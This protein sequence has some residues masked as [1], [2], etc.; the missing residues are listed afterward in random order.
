MADPAPR[1]AINSGYL[2]VAVQTLGNSL[3]R[4]RCKH[5][6]SAKAQ[7]DAWWASQS[8]R[9]QSLSS[10]NHTVSSDRYDAAVRVQDEYREAIRQKQLAA[11]G[12]AARPL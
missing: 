7:H 4:T 10:R 11:R 9:S 6:R 8:A 2:G 12:A 3:W 1:E 5:E